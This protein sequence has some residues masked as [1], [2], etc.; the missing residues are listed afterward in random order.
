M[1]SYH[2]AYLVVF[3]VLA[4]SQ[5]TTTRASASVNGGSQW[6]VAVAQERNQFRREARS[7]QAVASGAA[8]AWGLFV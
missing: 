6:D 2:T 5:L 4:K 1:A 7:H 8:G 3:G